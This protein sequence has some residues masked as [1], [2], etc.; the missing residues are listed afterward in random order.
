MKKEKGISL[1]VL[2]ITIIVMVIIATTIVISLKNAG[3][4]DKANQ[5]IDLT[6]ESQVQDFAAL[7]WA[8]AYTNNKRD[9][10]LI[11]SVKIKLEEQGITEQNWQINITN[12]GITIGN[13][14]IKRNLGAILTPL[15]Y[16]K[17]INYEANGVTDWKIFYHTKDYVYLIASEKLAYDKMPTRLLTE[18]GVNISEAVVQLGNNKTKV[19]GQI[20]WNEDAVALPVPETA[21]AKWMANWLDY[22]TNFNEKS[23]T[24]LLNENIWSVFVNTTD[25][26]AEYIEGAIGTPTAEMFVSSWNAKRLAERNTS[27][28]ELVLTANK[29]VGY[30]INNTVN[31]TLGEVDKLYI[32]SNAAS[33]SVWLASPSAYGVYNIMYAYH[34]SEINHL[35]YNNNNRG[36]RPVVCLKANVPV[37]L[38]TTTD[39]EL[40]K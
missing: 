22:S 4:I 11:E 10:N 27:K 21:S 12:T 39:F 14:N 18:T 2:V 29:L 40:I 38:G 35:S 26:Y 16:G 7:V 25:D 24:Y 17:T 20:Y 30:Y 36:V 5:A 15:D 9:E 28:N 8:D 3:I 19:V 23:V 37:K 31:C 33:S 6:N 13:R 32:W 34:G 1:I